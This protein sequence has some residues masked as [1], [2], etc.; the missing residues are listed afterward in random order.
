LARF[1]RAHGG[2][3]LLARLL[4]SGRARGSSLCVR[5]GLLEQ[6]FGPTFSV[7]PAMMGACVR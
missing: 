7:P 1:R 2:A 5:L 4:L 6:P 3:Q